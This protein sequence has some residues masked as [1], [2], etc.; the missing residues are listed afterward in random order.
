MQSIFIDITRYLQ[1]YSTKLLGDCIVVKVESKLT[2]K[3]ITLTTR[4]LILFY[5]VEY[6]VIL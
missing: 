5:L 2:N 4:L 6:G 1:L 3:S